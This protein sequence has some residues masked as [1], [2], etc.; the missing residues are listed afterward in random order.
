VSEAGDLIISTIFMSCHACFA[1]P[2]LFSPSDPLPWCQNDQDCGNGQLCN[3]N[4]CQGFPLLFVV[5]ENPCFE[6][7]PGFFLWYPPPR[8]PAAFIQPWDPSSPGFSGNQ[9]K[10]QEEGRGY[11]S[12]NPNPKW[13]EGLS[14]HPLAPKLRE[15]P[16]LE[17]KN[18]SFH[19]PIVGKR[20]W[21][22]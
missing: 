15:D 9:E 5:S 3:Q 21:Y 14:N 13:G 19:P 18:L 20:T 22:G 2:H 1:I 12:P 8:Q 4:A 6:L 7:H 11:P 10:L 17:P 16:I